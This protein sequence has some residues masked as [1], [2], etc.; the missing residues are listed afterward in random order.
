M[1]SLPAF[2]YWSHFHEFL[3]FVMGPCEVLLSSADKQ[4]IQDFMALSKP[5]QCLIVRF[6]NRKSIF[7]KPTSYTYQEVDDI[8]GNFKFLFQ[9]QWFK[10]IES[11]N[12]CSFIEHLTK[13]EIIQIID[14]LNETGFTE[15]PALVYKKSQAKSILVTSIV[16]S[17]KLDAVVTTSVAQSYWQGN[18][19]THISYFLYLY[20]GNFRSTLNQ[21]SMRDLGVMRTRKEQAQVMARFVDIDSAKSAF[22]LHSLLDELRTQ[23]H[24]LNH[25]LIVN[26]L[27]SLPRP[28]GTKANELDAK[29]KF[30]LA[31]ALLKEDA[32]HAIDVLKTINTS[33]AQEKWAREAYKLGLTDEVET[34]LN[35]MIDAPL[36]EDLLA[37]AED[38]LARKYH[39]KRTS[40][41][42]DMLRENSQT[43]LIDEMHKGAVE[44]G[45]IAYYEQRECKAFRTENEIWRALFGL[46]FWHEIFEL[47]GLGLTNEFEHVPSSLKTNQFYQLA[48]VHIERRLNSTDSKEKLIQQISQS[49]AKYYGQGNIIFRWR[50]NILERL[51]LL[52]NHSNPDALLSLLKA[53][54]QDWKNLS[55]GFPDLMLIENERLRFEEVKSEGDQLR[56][57]QLLSIQKL[58]SVGFDV[59]ITNVNWT[60]DPM[61]PYA[62]VDIEATGGR[63]QHHRITEVGIVKMIGGE[64]VAQWQSLI[65]PQRRIPQN[66]TALT[67][68]NNNMVA[69]A[70][71]FAE[72][73][74]DIDEFTKGCVFVAHN[75]NFDYGFIK[76]EFARVER[77]YRRPKLCTVREMRKH[78]KGLPSY[79]LANLT[80]HFGIDMQCHHR[81]MSDAIAAG[82]LLNM[83]NEKRLNNKS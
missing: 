82:E 18:F 49:A 28:I 31:C 66:I 22:E 81:A 4:F 45:V 24:S 8:P 63:A 29:V 1:R 64:V 74:D 61:Q 43:L 16:E 62:V 7:V 42:T 35:R 6:I 27:E 48:S 77:H 14:E 21:F 33:V 46:Y 69:D 58:Q 76:E 20:F 30:L 68:I 41:L 78:Y 39:K 54:T 56:R 25:S 79:S 67:G 80:R 70:P 2:Y 23:R 73:A 9:E 32:I 59:R 5:Q 10:P 65:N 19:E 53:M 44:R 52:I 38:F 55:D 40:V 17:A 37:F 26:H 83:V 3:K 36:S 51:I 15:K 34:E 57:N 12:V 11:S 75:V 60:I 50:K 13:G 71:L 72:V 47:E